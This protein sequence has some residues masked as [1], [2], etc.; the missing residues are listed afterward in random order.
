[1][2]LVA[3][4]ISKKKRILLMGSK[5]VCTFAARLPVRNEQPII[6]QN[7]NCSSSAST[8]LVCQHGERLLER[9]RNRDTDRQADS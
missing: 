5:V 4:N 1:M 3:L 8:Q 2:T 7:K 6:T 9:E